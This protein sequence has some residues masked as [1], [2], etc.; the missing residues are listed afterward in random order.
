MRTP[1]YGALMIISAMIGATL[2]VSYGEGLPG[3]LHGALLVTA[4]PIAFA[5]WLMTFRDLT[6]PRR[7]RRPPSSP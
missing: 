5:G 6:P 4:I 1:V 7:R 3:W 2:V